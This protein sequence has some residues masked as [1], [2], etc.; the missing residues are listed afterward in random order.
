M[1]WGVR[2][3]ARDNAELLK[4]RAEGKTVKQIAALMGR[5]EAAIKKRCVVLRARADQ[6]PRAPAEVLVFPGA[7]PRAPETPAADEPV[8]EPGSREPVEELQDAQWCRVCGG[9]IEA[10]KTRRFCGACGP[11]ARTEWRRGGCQDPPENPGSALARW[12]AA[13][14]VV[15][16]GHRLAG[17]PMRIPRFLA[18]FICAALS[19]GVSEAAL[20]ISRK[21]GKSAAIA[22]ML[23]GFLVGPLRRPGW[24]AAVVSVDRS[25]AGELIRQAEGIARA[26]GT[27]IIEAQSRRGLGIDEALPPD[28]VMVRR[29]P[30]PG[31]LSTDDARI[32]VLSADRV[33]G[34]SSS[35]DLVIVDETGLLQER[36]RDLVAGLE[37]SVSTKDGRLIHLSIRG[38]GPFVGEIETRAKRR[39]GTVAHVYAGAGGAGVDD[40]ENWRR[41]NPGLGTIKSLPYMRAAAEKAALTPAMEPAFRA[42]DLNERVDPSAAC[43]CPWARGGGVRCRKPPSRPG[44][45]RATSGP[46]WAQRHPSRGSVRIGRIR[47][48]PRCGSAPPPNRP[49]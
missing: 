45:A 14:L 18:R 19:P 5:T 38:D 1:P 42:F 20:V 44:R 32:Q 35:F 28:A 49:C 9:L 6:P 43:L 30:Y 41:G 12:A 23:L 15:P 33:S 7:A 46:T 16:P 10:P 22:V 29:T 4:L 26:S 21:N 3:T 40:E 24:R 8:P 25:K 13:H 37:T 31:E 47:G 36:H 39:A 27:P 48:G 2:W 11:Q 17:G 34:H